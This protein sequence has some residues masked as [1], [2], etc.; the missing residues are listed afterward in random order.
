LIRRR[1][2]GA[3]R[4]AALQFYGVLA[5]A[6]LGLLACR[7]PINGTAGVSVEVKVS[8]QPARVGPATVTVEM[9]DAARNPLANAD[10]MVEA[11][12]SHPGMAPVLAQAKEMATG[13][14]R[15]PINFN[16]GGDWVLLLYIKLADGRRMVRQVDVKGV[17]TN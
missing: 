13:T 2:S 12:M 6:C 15:A 17:Q 3:C 9:T 4:L 1:N 7:R 14:Y 5:L 10:I 16:M 11:E 8:P